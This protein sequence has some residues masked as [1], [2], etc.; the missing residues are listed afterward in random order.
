MDREV[1]EQRMVRSHTM[2]HENPHMGQYAADLHYPTEMGVNMNGGTMA[3]LGNESRNMQRSHV[4]SKVIDQT[5]RT[6]RR[7]EQ[8][9]RV[10][11]TKN[12]SRLPKS[13]NQ[14]QPNDAGQPVY[15]K[16]FEKA[17]KAGTAKGGITYGKKG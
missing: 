10:D 8:T 4:E 7:E 14:P 5:G 6:E 9:A 15:G 12:Y 2:T 17:A 1:S 16:L 13:M 11:V 3:P